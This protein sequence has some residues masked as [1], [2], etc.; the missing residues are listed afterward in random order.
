MDTTMMEL[1]E[2]SPQDLEANRNGYLSEVQNY[3]LRMKRQRAI[4]TGVA[5]ILVMAFI[6][7]FCIFLGNPIMAL[8]GISITICSAAMTGIFARYWMRVSGDIHE[9]K[10]LALTGKLEKVVRVQFRMLVYILRMNQGEFVVSK[11]T[12]NAFQH[13]AEYKLYRA[14]YS[15]ALLSA[16]KI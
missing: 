2:F 11:E 13:E 1:L 14:P 4:L 5:I 7:T 8:I 15:G 9:G 16:E 3:R 6:A 12:F 10:V